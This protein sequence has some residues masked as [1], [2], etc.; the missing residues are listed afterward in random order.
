V[1][2]YGFGYRQGQQLSLSGHGDRAAVPRDLG[3]YGF[4]NLLDRAFDTLAHAFDDRHAPETPRSR[5]QAALLVVAV[6][7]VPCAL[8][9]GWEW[10]PW[11]LGVLGLIG[12]VVCA[13]LYV[14][15][16]R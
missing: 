9:L 8:V 15:W 7:L 5:P 11:L 14:I 2:P 6:A 1:K 16:A 12:A 10:A 13:A 4:F 3:M